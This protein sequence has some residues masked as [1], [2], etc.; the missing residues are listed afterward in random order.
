[1]NIAKTTILSA[2][3][4]AMIGLAGPAAACT[5]ANPCEPE[6]PTTEKP[7]LGNP[8]NGKPVGRSPWDGITGNS[9]RNGADRP[10][11]APMDYDVQRDDTPFEQPGGKG[12]G[13]SPSGS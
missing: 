4:I 12:F 9:A 5:E 8:G 7:E 1:M 2:F 6:P 11:A 3:A 10:G 13:P